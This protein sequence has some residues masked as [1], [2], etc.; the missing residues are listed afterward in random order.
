LLTAL[1][2][3]HWF[4]LSEV[5]A[6]LK[7]G[8]RVLRI[9]DFLRAMVRLEAANQRFIGAGDFLWFKDIAELLRQHFPDR[10]KSIPNR[11]LPDFVV[12]ALALFQENMRAL[13]PMLGKREQ[14]D[15]RKAFELLQWKPRPSKE[16]VIVCGDSL[17]ANKLV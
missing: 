17:I 4:Y 11:R 7:S 2:K 1:I 15:C 9:L 10:S 12:K 6:L 13:K 5:T 3:N 16:A 8:T 14:L